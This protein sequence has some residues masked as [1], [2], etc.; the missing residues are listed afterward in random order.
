MLSLMWLHLVY[1]FIEL[2]GYNI[3][4]ISSASNCFFALAILA[5]DALRLSSEIDVSRRSGSGTGPLSCARVNPA[6]Y[7]WIDLSASVAVRRQEGSSL[8]WVRESHHVI[9][10]IRQKSHLPTAAAVIVAKECSMTSDNIPKDIKPSDTFSTPSN[11]ANEYIVQCSSAV[12][13]SHLCRR[14]SKWRTA[15]RP[16]VYVQRLEVHNGRY[17]CNRGHS[18]FIDGWTWAELCTIFWLKTC[19]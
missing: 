13:A 15:D 12:R 2:Q 18:V 11:W 7:L 4:Y 17:M 5:S 19:L 8:P 1:Q 16:S 14:R 10:E 9:K 3:G 6:W